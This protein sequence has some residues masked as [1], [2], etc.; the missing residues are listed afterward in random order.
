[1]KAEAPRQRPYAGNRSAQ[2]L[3]KAASQSS[4]VR[5]THDKTTEE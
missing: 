1:M 3:P 4:I 2:L 5:H